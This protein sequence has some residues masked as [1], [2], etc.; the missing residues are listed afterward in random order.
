MS[1]QKPSGGYKG[2]GAIPEQLQQ[3]PH[4]A[5]ESAEQI[6]QAG[7]GAFS[8]AQKEGGKVFNGLVQDGMALQKQAQALAQ[9]QLQAAGARFE[10]LTSRMGSRASEP[11]DK[12]ESLF[13]QRV[14]KALERLGIPSAEELQALKAQVES[15]TEELKQSRARESKGQGPTTHPGDNGGR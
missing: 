8:K 14:A 4:L 15:L 10:D 2:P 5:R 11:L 12:L 7:L 3:L 13:E 1:D 6:W 9:E